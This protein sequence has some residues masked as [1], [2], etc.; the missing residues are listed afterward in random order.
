M[1]LSNPLF[2]PETHGGASGAANVLW[3]FN[4]AESA[5]RPRRMLP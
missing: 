2:V 4:A 3:L 5:L 1:D